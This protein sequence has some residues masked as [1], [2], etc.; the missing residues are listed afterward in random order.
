MHA[1]PHTLGKGWRP[2]VNLARMKSMC[3]HTWT[4]GRSRSALS[5]NKMGRT[6]QP[7][8]R[9]KGK[10]VHLPPWSGWRWQEAG[11]CSVP[12][13]RTLGSWEPGL[14]SGEWFLVTYPGHMLGCCYPSQMILI[15]NGC[16]GK[17]WDSKEVQRN[18]R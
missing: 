17:C 2:F 11:V 16:L 3:K 7:C 4:P 5:P 18:R 1:H 10:T 8:L 15:L 6:S 13:S 12:V 9:L 14:G